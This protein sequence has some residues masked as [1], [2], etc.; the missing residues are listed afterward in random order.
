MIKEYKKGVSV[1]I[2]D[3]FSSTEFDCHCNYPACKTTLIDSELV[4]YLEKKRIQL[5]KP[6]NI[7]SGF[8]CLR[9]NRDV[10]SGDTSQHPKGKA[11]DIVSGK[12][13]VE[14]SELFQDAGGLGIYKKK[15]FLHVDT[16]SKK[17]R[18]FA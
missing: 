2:S 8:R 5:G 16:R 13:I 6:I 1:K 14:Q 3:H 10:G 15:K 7:N 17:A 18:W 9:H 4:N 12:N 11:S